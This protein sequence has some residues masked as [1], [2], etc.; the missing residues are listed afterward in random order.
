[1][2]DDDM[3]F[4][5]GA[6]KSAALVL[7]PGG[8]PRVQA[9]ERH[10]VEMLNTDLDSLIPDDHQVRVVWTFANEADLSV[11]YA[12]IRAVEGR[13]GR[14]PIDPRILL[15]LWLFATLR[16]VGSARQLDGLCKEHIAYR[17]LCGGVSV[18]Y[19]T[20]ADFRADSGGAFETLLTGSVAKL[21]AAGLVTMDRVAHDGMRVRAN[22]GSGS[23]RRKETLER[24]QQEA[25]EQVQ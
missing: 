6:A 21:R 25:E 11:L 1:M 13:A 14:T 17:W 23:F 10:Q 16:A 9:P 3:L 4:A 12:Q 15:S 20:L 7:V 22:A 24:F 18:N 19:H 2:E 5:V 8:V